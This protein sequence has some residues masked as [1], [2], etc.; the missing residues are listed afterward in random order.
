MTRSTD[1]HDQ[2]AP[3][4]LVILVQDAGDLWTTARDQMHQHAPDAEVW[5]LLLDHMDDQ[6]TA[7][8][9]V[10]T[11]L[12]AHVQG[13][14][15]QHYLFPHDESEQTTSDRLRELAAQLATLRAQLLQASRAASAARNSARLLPSETKGASS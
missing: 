12:G 9:D 4:A 2:T 11:T 1:E 6:L 5:P 14:D 13:Y 8:A 3:E 7:M 15:E 10:M